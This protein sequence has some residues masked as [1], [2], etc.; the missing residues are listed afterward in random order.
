[1]ITKTIENVQNEL[2]Q[3]IAR[4]ENYKTVVMEDLHK[5]VYWYGDTF[6]TD[7]FSVNTYRTVLIWLS[8]ANAGEYSLDEVKGFALNYIINKSQFIEC[9]DHPESYKKIAKLS[10]MSNI[11]NDFL[12]EL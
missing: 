12:R 10:A 3:I 7:V 9:K 6:K 1:M 4:I 5:A 11:Y 8:K 2:N